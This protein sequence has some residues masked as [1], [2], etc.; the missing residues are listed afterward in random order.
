MSGTLSKLSNNIEFI[1]EGNAI[2]FYLL[3]QEYDDINIINLDIDET[4]SESESES[5]SE[6]ELPEGY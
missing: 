3:D 5:E 1:N 2:Q 4:V 6:D